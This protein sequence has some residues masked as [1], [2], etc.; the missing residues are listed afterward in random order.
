VEVVEVEA[1]LVEETTKLWQSMRRRTTREGRRGG[2]GREEEKDEEVT[3]RM[4]WT[5]RGN[6]RPSPAIQL[7][8]ETLHCAKV[9]SV[10]PLRHTESNGDVHRYPQSTLGSCVTGN[11]RYAPKRCTEISWLV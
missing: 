1:A 7:Q 11:C 4:C 9:V 5:R 8:L 10:L 6:K 3:W 2:R